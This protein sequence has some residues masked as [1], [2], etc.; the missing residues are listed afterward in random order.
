MKERRH[1]IRGTKQPDTDYIYHLP[2]LTEVVD[3]P[4]T[5]EII[6]TPD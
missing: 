5:A 3:L 1:S 6:L 4:L 2:P